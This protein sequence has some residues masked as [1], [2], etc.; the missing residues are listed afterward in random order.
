MKSLA[1]LINSRTRISFF[2]SKQFIPHNLFSV[3]LKWLPITINQ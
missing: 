1:M 2:N 3:H